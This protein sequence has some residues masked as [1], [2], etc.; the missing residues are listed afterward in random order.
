MYR[1]KTVYTWVYITL[2]AALEGEYWISP[3]LQ[4]SPAGTA[5]GSGQSCGYTLMIQTASTVSL[6]TLP[7]P[8]SPWLLAPLSLL[9]SPEEGRLG[10]SSGYKTR[11]SM[12]NGNKYVKSRIHYL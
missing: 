9:L 10:S 1:K 4:I 12:D 5:N 3:S 6:T 8:L 7:L 11:G 2:Y